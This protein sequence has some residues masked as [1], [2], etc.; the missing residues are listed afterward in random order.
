MGVGRVDYASFG[1]LNF[2]VAIDYITAQS[3]S[4][5]NI[6]DSKIKNSLEDR[7]CVK[8]EV[9]ALTVCVSYQFISNANQTY[10]SKKAQ[11]SC[12]L[13]VPTEPMRASTCHHL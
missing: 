1:F 12:L 8:Y 4:S 9:W 13:I 3:V 11:H 7:E 6:N 5:E 10:Y 2:T